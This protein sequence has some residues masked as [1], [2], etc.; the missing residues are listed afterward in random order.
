VLLALAV[1]ADAD[2]VALVDLELEV[3]SGVCSK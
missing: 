2:Q 3:L 1:E